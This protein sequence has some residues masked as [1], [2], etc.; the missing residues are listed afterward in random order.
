MNLNTTEERLEENPHVLKVYEILK[1]SDIDL[2]EAQLYH[3]FP[4][5]KN[6]DDKI[7]VS[8]L[9]LVSP[10]YGITIFC[11]SDLHNLSTSD[12]VKGVIQEL[13]DVNGQIISRLFKYSGLRKG[14][15]GLKIP[16]RSC[17]VALDLD[18]ETKIP[19]S[20]PFDTLYTKQHII[21]YFKEPAFTFNKYTFA[22]AVSV[23]EGGK[24]LIKQNERNLEG[25]SETS[26]VWKVAAVETK[27]LQFDKD[28]KQGYMPPLDG[29]QRIRG[30]AGSGKTVVLAMKV[31]QTILRNPE[32]TVLY[33]FH[34]KSL[35]Q[36]VKRLITRFYRQFHDDDPDF[37]N[38]IHIRHAWGGRTNPGVYYDACLQAGTS[39][40]TLITAR[41]HNSKDPFSYCCEKLLSE[42]NLN[43]SYDYIFVDEAQDFNEN[44]L[45]LCLKLAR[46]E[47]IILGA[48]VFQNIFQSKI[49]KAKDILGEDR[50]FVE[51][52]FLQTCYR[53]PLPV[54]VCAH[55]IG[56]GSYG[57]QV[58]RIETTGHWKDLGYDVIGKEGEEHFAETE[59]VTVERPESRSPSFSD[60][61]ANDLIKTYSFE[62]MQDEIRHVV[63]LINDDIINQ[64]VNP[65]DI[66]VLSA[67]DR[68]CK[69][70]F[71]Y[72]SEYLQQRNINTNDINADKY[73]I[74]DFSIRGRVTLSTIHKAKGNEAYCVYIVGCDALFLSSDVRSRNLLFTAMTRTKGW[75]TMSGLGESSRNLFN[76]VKKAKD[77]SPRIIFSYPTQKDIERIDQ[78]ISIAEKFDSKQ[79]KEMSALIDEIGGID[80]LAE[81]MEKHS[82]TRNKK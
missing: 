76:E 33:T 4:L 38:R 74:S 65:D 48:D 13:D 45:K 78:D 34:T 6:D 51:D 1:R 2:S 71:R 32:A 66:L 77:N 82:A 8:Q 30:L 79:L 23:I 55:A 10:I 9:L 31:A 69:Q 14:A 3:D 75:L 39:P 73:S 25:F 7:I 68:Y 36:H 5:Y 56:L 61:S 12:D 80:K 21:Q 24:G 18:L 54:L 40:L 41:E 35:Y 52:R 43:A 60:E 63:N 57:I 47:R 42:P 37:Y 15:M 58:Q 19:Q 67:D 44:F 26:K 17:I 22:E 70:Y 20:S 29:P 72:L 62:S 64:G 46:E 11:C 81:L 49:P 28:Q 16:V 53:T 27:I 50:D 59:V